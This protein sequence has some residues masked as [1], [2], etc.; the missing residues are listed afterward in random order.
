M[1]ANL[2]ISQN[3]YLKITTRKLPHWEL[4][5]SIYH[6]TFVTWERL[7]LKESAR[8][9]VLNS[10][11]FFHL[12]RYEIFAMVIMPDHV[13]LLIQPWVKSDHDGREVNR[14]DACSTEY[15]SLSSIMHSIKSYTARQIP[16]V[17][18]H[19]GTV[20]EDESHDHIIRNYQE[21]QDTWQYIR[22]NPVQAGLSAN[23]ET[24]PFLWESNK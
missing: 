3:P 23:P 16:K 9:I 5:G 20:W 8:E 10:C 19:I 2:P 24:Y 11:L 22:Q 1:S 17:M 12:Q 4:N 15:W 6:I 13:H 21:F 18:K 14:R 7:E